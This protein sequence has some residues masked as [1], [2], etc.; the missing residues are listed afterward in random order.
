MG[1]ELPPFSNK[2]SPGGTF[3][4]RIYQRRKD[5]ERRNTFFYCVVDPDPDGSAGSTC[6][7]TN[8]IL[9][10]SHKGVEQTEI[11]LAK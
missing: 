10:F 1:N 4:E 5:S 7:W 9:L 8:W 2:S 3:T 6:F 11:M